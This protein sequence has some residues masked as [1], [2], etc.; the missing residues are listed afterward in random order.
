[1]FRRF[2]ISIV[3]LL[4]LAASTTGATP[5]VSP[6]HAARAAA[7]AATHAALFDK[8]RVV[9]HLAIAYGVF[10]HWVYVPFRSGQLSIHHPLKLTKA[11][12]ALLFAVHEVKKALA[13]TSHSSSPTLKALNGVLVGISGK[14]QSVG[15]LFKSDPASLTDGQVSG[16]IGD[17][18]SQVTHSNSILHVPDAPVSQLGNFS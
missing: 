13:I 14:F 9:L 7:P 6:A 12:L 16:A 17:L 15:T 11:G 2:V 4:A 18:N 10:H 3:L 8:T 5:R 1:M